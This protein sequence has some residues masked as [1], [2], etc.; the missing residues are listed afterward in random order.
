METDRTLILRIKTRP[1]LSWTHNEY[2]RKAYK[3][4]TI[5]C[6][7]EGRV[8]VVDH[9]HAALVG[10]WPR[11]VKN[12]KKISVTKKYEVVVIHDCKMFKYANRYFT[13]LILLEV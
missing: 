6:P 9:D 3:K 10:G 5:T 13:G 8:G 11:S 2:G 4:F 12:L 1:E 7:I